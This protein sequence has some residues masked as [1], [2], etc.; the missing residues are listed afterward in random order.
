M[1]D[2]RKMRNFF[3][4]RHTHT[5]IKKTVRNIFHAVHIVTII[6]AQLKE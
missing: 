5:Q 2:D 1:Y 4:E 3:K 6:Q